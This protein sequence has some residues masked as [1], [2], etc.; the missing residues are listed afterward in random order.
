[1]R[2]GVLLSPVAKGAGTPRSRGGLPEVSKTPAA[3]TLLHPKTGEP[4]G[5]PGPAGGCPVGDVHQVQSH[6]LF[7][8]LHLSLMWKNTPKMQP[9]AYLGT[10]VFSSPARLQSGL[11]PSPVHQGSSSG[12]SHCR[13]PGSWPGWR[14]GR[15]GDGCMDGH[16]S[17]QLCRDTR[18]QVPMAGP[19]VMSPHHQRCVWL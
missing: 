5:S 19:W 10:P 14:V 6:W 9:S 8:V 12:S 18:H 3:M 2:T 7:L 13:A 1:M 16:K 11:A 4:S 17:L 15:M